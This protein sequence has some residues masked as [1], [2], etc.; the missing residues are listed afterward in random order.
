MISANLTSK[1][2]AALE[3]SKNG[4]TPINSEEFDTG[5]QAK[6]FNQ[7]DE[8]NQFTDTVKNRRNAHSLAEVLQFKESHIKTKKCMTTLE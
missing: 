5:L 7:D 1:N 2:N 6:E 4:S 8:I 3:P